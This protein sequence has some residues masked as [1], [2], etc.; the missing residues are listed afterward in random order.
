MINILYLT[1]KKQ[2]GTTWYR[3]SQFAN[4]LTKQNLA[5][6]AFIDWRFDEEMLAKAIEKADLF[7]IRPSDYAIQILKYASLL[8]NKKPIVAD[9]DDTFHFIDPFNNSYQYMGTKEVTLPDGTPLW[10]DGVAGFSVVSNK[11]RIE[12]IKETLKNVDAITTTTFELKE[13]AELFNPNV[14]VIPNCINPDLFPPIKLQKDN[15]IKI[16][17]SGGSSHFQDLF[18]IQP[19]IKKVMEENLNVEFHIA[20]QVFK[21][22][23]KDLPQS[24]I[25]TYSWLSPDAH[26]FRLAT[27]G[28]DIGICPLTDEKFNTYKSSIKFYEYSALKIPTVAKDIP[29]Y[30]VDIVRDKTGLLYSDTKELKSHLDSLIKDPLK[31]ITLGNNAYDYVMKYRTIDEVA[32]DYAKFL[33]GV[34]NANKN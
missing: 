13:Y 8:K 5:N 1:E 14:V 22:A 24:R 2:D 28:A 12:A 4:S 6:T 34:I 7:I 15:V 20:G 31:R 18:E 21:G 10:K 27:I 19:V 26:G 17:W 25:K 11:N 29:P 16:L 23:I 33:I 30:S 3:Y 32:K 9:I